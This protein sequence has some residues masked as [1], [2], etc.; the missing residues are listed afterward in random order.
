MEQTAEVPSDSPDVAALSQIVEK[1]ISA[2]KLGDSTRVVLELALRVDVRLI[3]ST[4][5]DLESMITR[6]G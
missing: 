1:K 6:D 5:K 3:A 2:L 4:N